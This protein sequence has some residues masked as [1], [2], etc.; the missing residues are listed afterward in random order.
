MG[1]CRSHH[2]ARKPGSVLFSR[3]VDVPLLTCRRDDPAHQGAD[4]GP[5][6]R[7]VPVNEICPSI[8][9][10]PS[11]LHRCRGAEV[12]ADC[13]GSIIMR[14]PLYRSTCESVVS[15]PAG[16]FTDFSGS[17]SSLIPLFRQIRS[18]T[19]KDRNIVI[20]I[21]IASVMRI[22]PYGQIPSKT[23]GS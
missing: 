15:S 3:T 6:V 16:L 9:G 13:M 2:P 19:L 22:F 18:F 23:T 17:S 11:H 20:Y 8:E 7:E 21:V 4:G 14:A 1:P 12:L 10:N 5:V